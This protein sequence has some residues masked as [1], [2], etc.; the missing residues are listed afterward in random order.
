MAVELQTAELQTAICI[1]E[2][3]CMETKVSGQKS[4]DNSGQ[5]YQCLVKN[6]SAWALEM[7]NLLLSSFYVYKMSHN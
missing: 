3:L 2:L 5:N 4:V 6:D 7:I 1:L